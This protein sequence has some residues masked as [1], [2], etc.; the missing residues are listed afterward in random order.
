VTSRVWSSSWSSLETSTSILREK[1][2]ALDHRR[3]SRPTA[4]YRV[5]DSPKHSA[6]APRPSPENLRT[7]AA[8]SDHVTFLD[9]ISG[10]FSRVSRS[11]PFSKKKDPRRWGSY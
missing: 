2:R 5:L 6:A 10:F 7:A 11:V 4:V 9:P 1:A 3:N 8:R